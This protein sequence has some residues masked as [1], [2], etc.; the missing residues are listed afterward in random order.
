MMRVIDKGFEEFGIKFK[1]F[2]GIFA[3]YV[4]LILL[5]CFL[6]VNWKTGFVILGALVLMAYVAGNFAIYFKTGGFIPVLLQR[7][8]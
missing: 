1:A 4:V 5:S 7:I 6:F 3:M 8:N 2:V